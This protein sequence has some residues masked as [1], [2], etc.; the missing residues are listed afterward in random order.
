MFKA[1]KCIFCIP[2][3]HGALM[4]GAI[5]V[6]R[7]LANIALSEFIP[8]L[9]EI[10]TAVAF[11]TMM[12]RDIKKTRMIFFA[13]YCSYILVINSM[14][15]YLRKYPTQEEQFSK[16]T[17]FQ[18]WCNDNIEDYEYSSIDECVTMLEARMLR[19][20]LIFIAV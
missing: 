20:E 8:A 13:A 2:V 4:I 5:H 1:K 12:W 3:H 15:L 10:V 11:M 16:Q 7:L 19:D 18:N 6:F 17:W 14:E 9:G